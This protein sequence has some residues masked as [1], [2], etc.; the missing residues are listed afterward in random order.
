MEK[1][2][3]PPTHFAFTAIQIGIGSGQRQR[4]RTPIVRHSLKTDDLA[5]ARAQRDIL[6]GAG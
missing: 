5:K 6:V 1:V 3:L 4:S 2:Q